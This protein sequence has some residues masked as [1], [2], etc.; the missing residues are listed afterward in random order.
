MH[1]EHLLDDTFEH[2]DTFKP[3]CSKLGDQGFESYRLFRHDV[4]E[5]E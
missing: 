2:I 1:L 5:R 4:L 3:M